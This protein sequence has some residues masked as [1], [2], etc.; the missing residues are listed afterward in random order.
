MLHK[1][2]LDCCDQLLPQFD[3]LRHIEFQEFCRC[4]SDRRNTQDFSVFNIHMILPNL[5]ARIVQPR[6][7]ACFRIKCGQIWPFVFISLQACPGE[8]F[9]RGQTFMLLRDNMFGL[10][11]LP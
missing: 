11:G 7:I 6:E 8:I 5:L 3:T 9:Q 2:P 4:A 10:K 1:S